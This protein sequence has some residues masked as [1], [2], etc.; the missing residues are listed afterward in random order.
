LFAWWWDEERSGCLSSGLSCAWLL[1]HIF[2]S[3]TFSQ[4]D[5]VWRLL[6][7][8]RRHRYFFASPSSSLFWLPLRQFVCVSLA[9]A[10]AIGAQDGTIEPNQAE[11]LNQVQ[12]GKC[13]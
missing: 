3:S 9:F 5:L 4:T 7:A 1:S 10:S 12:V 2:L 6:I 8:Q 13:R 11:A